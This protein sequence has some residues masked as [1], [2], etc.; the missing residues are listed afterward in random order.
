MQVQVN[1]NNHIQ[2]G[3]RLTLWVKAEV[4]AKLGRF[5]AHL[6]RVDAHL[7]DENGHKSGAADKK[8]V[9]ETRPIGLHPMAVTHAAATLEQAVHGATEKLVHLLDHAFGHLNAVKG[10]VPAGGA[11]AP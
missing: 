2:G 9:L 4:E 5:A 8:C 10:R 3:E 7:S 1:A 11:D 6:I